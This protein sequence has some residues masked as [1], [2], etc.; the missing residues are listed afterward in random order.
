MNERIVTKDGL[1]L[2]YVFSRALSVT[3]G[4]VLLAHGITADLNEHEGLFRKAAD[5]FTA[6]GMNVLRFDFR[7]HGSSSVPQE[8]A[9]IEGEILDIAAASDDLFKRTGNKQAVLGCSFGAVSASRLVADRQGDVVVAFVMWNPVLDVRATFVRPGTEWSR[10][11]INEESLPKINSGEL[12]HVMLDDFRLG[13]KMVREMQETALP[14]PLTSI[15]VPILAFHGDADDIVPYPLTRA[16]LQGR[17]K[18]DLRTLIGAGHGF[19][20]RQTEVIEETASWLEDG[21]QSDWQ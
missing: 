7:G 12:A 19:A 15:S 11:A 6:R 16:A 14:A 4:D 1:K 18:T 5:E 8:R 13:K 20:D 3:I 17:E 21:F 2:N 9:D 10:Q